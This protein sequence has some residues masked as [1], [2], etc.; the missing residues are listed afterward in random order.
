[1]AVEDADG[2][3]L[4]GQPF[5]FGTEFPIYICT[6]A[7]EMICTVL[8]GYEGTDLQS[9]GI[10]QEHDCAGHGE[11]RRTENAAFDRTHSGDAGRAGHGRLDL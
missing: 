3:G 11:T 1:M 10:L 8:L 6:Q 5:F 4:A 9:L 7:V 2:P